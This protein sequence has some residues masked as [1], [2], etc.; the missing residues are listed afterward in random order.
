MAEIT[1]LV[2]DIGGTNVRLGI[3]RVRPDAIS[4]QG[5]KVYDARKYVSPDSVIRHYREA[6][7]EAIVIGVAGP[8]VENVATLTN[9]GWTL[10]A[11]ELSRIFQIPVYLLND[12]QACAYGVL[13]APSSSLVTLNDAEP[14]PG[15][16]AVIAAG[17]GLGEAGMFWDGQQHQPWACEGGHCDFAPRSELDVELYFYLKKKFVHVSWERVLSGPGLVNIYYFL[18][19][20][21]KM[22]GSLELDVQT[23][24]M[25]LPAKISAAALA[26]SSPTAVVALEL[27]CKYYAAEASNLALKTMALGGVYIAGG[28]APKILPF[29]KKPS[30]IAEFTN[31]GR[32]S[33]LLKTIPV[34]VVVDELIGLVGAA[35]FVQRKLRKQK[36]F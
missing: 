29:L 19:F 8:V 25:D 14:K 3:A 27:F 32:L 17:T 21:K 34:Y 18:K 9:L 16:K 11:G 4:V 20:E 28:I 15:N 26:N 35:A 31:V 6:K 13:V 10:S 24:S 7:P 23:E 36:P 33:Q 30:F 2:G 12:L 22:P 1:V 5:V